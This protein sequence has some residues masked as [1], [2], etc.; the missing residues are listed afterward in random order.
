MEIKG[1][2]QEFKEL[3]KFFQQKEEK[4]TLGRTSIANEILKEMTQYTKEH[5][6]KSISSE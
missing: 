1:S 2:I 5:G 4:A 3:M 6:S